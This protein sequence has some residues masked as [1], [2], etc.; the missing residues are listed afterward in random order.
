MLCLDLFIAVVFGHM[1]LC[2]DLF[3]AVVFGHIL[4]KKAQVVPQQI[5]KS[6][7]IKKEQ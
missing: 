2:L 7:W 3:I 4:L 6:F 1:V 5:R